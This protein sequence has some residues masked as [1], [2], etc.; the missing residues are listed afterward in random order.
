[1]QVPSFIKNIGIKGKLISMIIVILFI[2]LNASSFNTYRSFTKKLTNDANKQALMGINTTQRK[3]G[4]LSKDIQQIAR[5]QSIRPNFI[6]AIEHDTPKLIL[7]G[8][9]FIENKPNME[10]IFFSANEKLLARVS[11]SASSES[12]TDTDSNR[13]H[14]KNGEPGFRV[15]NKD[16]ILEAASPVFNENRQVGTIVI[17]DKPFKDHTFVDALKETQGTE[18]TVFCDDIRL[19]TTVQTGGKR[20]IGTKLDD[21][22]IL[23]TVLDEG[24]EHSGEANVTG[25]PHIA[26]YRPLLD[27]EGKKIGMIFTGISKA[28]IQEA[29]KQAFIDEIMFQVPLNLLILLATIYI[30][31]R[32]IITPLLRIIEYAKKVAEG[33]LDAIIKLESR[34]DEL[35]MLEKALTQM[36]TNLKAKIRQA[37]DATED[38]EQKAILAE[39]ATKEAEEARAQT[40]LAKSEGF[41]LAADRLE[42]VVVGIVEATGEVSEIGDGLTQN[43]TNMAD[44]TT[45]VA[46]AMEEMNSTVLEVARNAG[47][48]ADGSD[49]AKKKAHEGDESMQTLSRDLEQVREK[50][51]SLGE[52]MNGLSISAKDID[53]IINV[54]NDIAD[55]TNLLALNAAIEAARA[56][57]AGRGFAVVADEVRKL[58]EKTQNATKEVSQTI[59]TIQERVKEGGQMVISTNETVEI[60]GKSAIQ[61]GR[62]LTEIVNTSDATADQV[63]S[64]AT[65]AEE[66]SAT[67]EEINRSTADIHELTN[68]T[69]IEVSKAMKKVADVIA[70]AKT[71]EQIQNDLRTQ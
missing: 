49:H 39:Q 62:A 34:Q 30:L 64:I 69:N 68:V 29:I 4:E 37:N 31:D 45:G 18:I 26:I 13:I 59:H 19:S 24:K 40:I 16:I 33:D 58:A 1:M 50:V 44:R 47:S 65:A 63:R 28:S 53:Q 32:F 70:L 66:Q 6:H 27:S 14:V 67:S 57:D 21:E 11:N 48:A 52:M 42:E 43:V 12:D 22:L 35:G 41:K 36:V 56:G 17:V 71:L 5:D 15:V 2:V 25:I 51:S 9:K 60:A 54:I 3:L 46:T 61:T 38:A 23:K 20:A 8:K 55:Q 10:I 7:L